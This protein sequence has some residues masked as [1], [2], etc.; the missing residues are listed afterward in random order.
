MITWVK[1][2]LRLF[3]PCRLCMFTRTVPVISHQI[4]FSI[5]FFLSTTLKVSDLCSSLCPTLT[6]NISAG[7]A[8]AP[9]FHQMRVCSVS[10]QVLVNVYVYTRCV[11]RTDPVHHSSGNPDFYFCWMPDAQR[12]ISAQNRLGATGCRAQKPTKARKN[13]AYHISLLR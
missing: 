8:L 9:N 11:C 7:E 5:F 6:R 10:A 2:T 12:G 4:N 3:I 1:L 13:L